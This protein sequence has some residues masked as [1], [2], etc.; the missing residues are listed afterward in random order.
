MTRGSERGV[1]A[2]EVIGVV[3]FVLFVAVCVW[4]L[5]I[6]GYAA[7]HATEAARAAARAAALHQSAESAGLSALPEGLRERATISGSR[8]GNGYTYT[9]VVEVPM[10]TQ[11]LLGPVRRTVT[12]PGIE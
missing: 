3:P 10:L 12:M 6:G 7:V 9:A 2:L 1:A 4:Q 5:A 8:V 11:I